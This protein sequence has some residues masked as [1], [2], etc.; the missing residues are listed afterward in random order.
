M[1]SHSKSF[2]RA[3][4][5]CLLMQGLW[6]L[7]WLE[8]SLWRQSHTEPPFQPSKRRCLFGNERRRACHFLRCPRLYE[9]M[10][11]LDSLVRNLTEFNA[12]TNH[13][14][15]FKIISLLKFQTYTAFLPWFQTK[16][17]CPLSHVCLNRAKYTI[18]QTLE[19]LNEIPSRNSFVQETETNLI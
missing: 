5:S 9:V 3:T 4:S 6:L 14:Y 12:F 7:M 16:F 10:W 18:W 2:E 11:G 8:N 1:A 17:W 19:E 15:F 13:K